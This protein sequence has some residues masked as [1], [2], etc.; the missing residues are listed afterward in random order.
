MQHC[1]CLLLIKHSMH[2]YPRGIL[3][4]WGQGSWG[5]G[6]SLSKLGVIYAVHC[7]EAWVQPKSMV[8]C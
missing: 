1:F 6:V 7:C 4:S 8:G 2:G 5:R 3:G